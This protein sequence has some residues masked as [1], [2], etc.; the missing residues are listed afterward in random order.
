MIGVH[1]GIILTVSA[2]IE[3][4][5]TSSW[6]MCCD[7]FSFWEDLHGFTLV[8]LNE[9]HDLRNIIGNSPSELMGD[10]HE[11]RSH[12]LSR[13]PIPQTRVLFVWNVG[14]LVL[15]WPLD[16]FRV[17]QTCFAYR[18]FG[19]KGFSWLCCRT[20]LWY[21]VFAHLGSPPS[22]LAGPGSMAWVG[23]KD[24]GRKHWLREMILTR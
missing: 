14:S 19:S 6:N 2:V 13:F 24:Y 20:W 23:T 10:T 11:R 5:K 17:C 18:P 1:F 8:K 12:G 7:A 22:M 4:D 21:N 16:A 9:R 3:G 15:L